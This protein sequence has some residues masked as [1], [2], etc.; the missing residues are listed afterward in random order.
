M[1]KDI[2]VGKF[3]EL[4]SSD[5]NYATGLYLYEYKSEKLLNSRGDFELYGSM[6]IGP[7]DHKTNFS[8]K[9]MDHCGSYKKTQ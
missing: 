3:F 5:K 1:D 9:I 6:I 2:I 8:F 4:A 7:V